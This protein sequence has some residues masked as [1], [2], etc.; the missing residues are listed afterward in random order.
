[1][2]QGEQGGARETA[3]PG[4]S[5]VY[6][7][8]LLFEIDEGTGRASSRETAWAGHLYWETQKG[9][10]GRR[11]GSEGRRLR[12]APLPGQSPEVKACVVA[13]QRALP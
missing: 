8:Q 13:A 6:V 11:A 12:V 9:W 5:L 1:M 4:A 7:L 10:R 2:I 3:G